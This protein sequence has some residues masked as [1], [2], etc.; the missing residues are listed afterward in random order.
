[1]ITES[2]YHNA[3]F[4]VVRETGL[5]PVRHTTHAPQ[6][7]LSANSSTRAYQAANIIIAPNGKPCQQFYA[8]SAKI[9][10]ER[11]FSSAAEVPSDFKTLDSFSGCVKSLLHRDASAGKSV[12]ALS[13]CKN[14]LADRCA[15][16]AN[17]SWTVLRRAALSG[18]PERPRV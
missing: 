9:F 4:D 18:P 7:C 13:T 6:T 15:A 16:N 12:K 14:A 8:K 3:A 1:M 2:R 11:L 5:E 17:V 10:Y